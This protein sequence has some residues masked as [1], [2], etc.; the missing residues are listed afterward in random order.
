MHHVLAALVLLCRLKSADVRLPCLET[1][2]RADETKF[3][4]VHNLEA[5]IE[6]GALSILTFRTD[7][8]LSMI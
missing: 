1:W 2:S 8:K 4:L 7:C 5:D 6:S 3:L